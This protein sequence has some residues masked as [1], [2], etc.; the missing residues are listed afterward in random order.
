[1][2]SQITVA[3]YSH[4]PCVFLDIFSQSMEIQDIFYSRNTYVL[5]RHPFVYKRSMFD[6]S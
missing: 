5:K 4:L 6:F 2:L 3:I 1:M